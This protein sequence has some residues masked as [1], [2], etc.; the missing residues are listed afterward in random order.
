MKQ[1]KNQNKVSRV[2]KM[3]KIKITYVNCLKL[4]KQIS[5][6]LGLQYP[7]KYMDNLIKKVYNLIKVQFVPKQIF[8]TEVLFKKIQTKIQMNFLFK[9]LEENDLKIVI[10]AFEELKIQKGYT[11]IK[12]GDDGDYLYVNIF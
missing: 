7:L 10:D 8:K 2:N 1:T 6:N 9:D 3:T 4:Y 11:V 12:Q 5:Q